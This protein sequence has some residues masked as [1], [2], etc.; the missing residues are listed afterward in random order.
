MAAIL[1]YNGCYPKALASVC[2]A[3]IQTTVSGS[4]NYLLA[5]AN[6][7]L[8]AARCLDAV[9]LQAARKALRLSNSIGDRAC[10]ALVWSESRLPRGAAILARERTRFALKMRTT[11]F[12]A[13]DIAP[14]I[15]RALTASAADDRLPAAHRA[16]SITHRIL[17]LEQADT[18]NGIVPANMLAQASFN[19]CAKIAAIVSR[20]V[21]LHTWQAE[22]RAELLE[23]PI[24]PSVDVL[25]PPASERGMAAYLNNFYSTPLSASGENKYT[26][27][28]AT[29]GPGC[30]G[31]LLS[32]VSHMQK[33]V[34]KLR[35]LAAVRRGRKEMF[36][37]PIAAPGRTFFEQMEAEAAEADADGTGVWE[38]EKARATRLGDER[39][40]EARKCTPCT[41]CGTDVEDPY[42]VL[43][44]CSDPGT[45]DARAEFIR[46]LPA[47]LQHLLRL[48]V[49]PCHVVLASCT[50]TTSR[51]SLV[52]NL[53]FNTLDSWRTKWIGPQLMESSSCFTC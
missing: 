26:T 51:K 29:R 15:F 17:Q 48:C 2:T 19:D 21:C 24:P 5:F 6:P 27:V 44:S 23:N 37:A 7:S 49:L 10:N 25:R 46:D 16:K 31:G 22:S 32:Q 9:S 47:R 1:Q 8:G 11:P 40:A 43:V 18:L 52:V 30:C 4:T 50:P 53:C 45:V 42:L 13:T 14:R 41:L 33:L 3:D 36:N 34:P 20:R 28:I 38:G 12:G 35:A 39:R